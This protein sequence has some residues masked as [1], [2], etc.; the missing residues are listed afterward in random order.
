M[1]P[2]WAAS[3]SCLCWYCWD[4]AVLG[5]FGADEAPV[6][7]P[8][9][10]DW[11]KFRFL[12]DFFKGF[13]LGFFLVFFS[14]APVLLQKSRWSCHESGPDSSSDSSPPEQ[15]WWG[16]ASD[17]TAALC[18][19]PQGWG[20]SCCCQAQDLFLGQHSWLL[21]MP[22]CAQ[23]AHSAPRAVRVVLC[24]IGAAPGSLKQGKIRCCFSLWCY[25]IT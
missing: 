11:N 10:F 2:Q 17:V 18:L 4:S 6:F 9:I 21:A 15:N 5:D 22:V 7:D 19:V 13:F 23:P 24:W 1:A 3:C 20:L 14:Q 8:F 12:L 16:V 25:I